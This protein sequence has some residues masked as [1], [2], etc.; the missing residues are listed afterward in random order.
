MEFW[1]TILVYSG[2]VLLAFT[3]L[4]HVHGSSITRC[5]AVR[6]RSVTRNFSYFAGFLCNAEKKIFFSGETA[7]DLIVSANEILNKIYAW[8]VANSLHINC[9][10]SKAVLFRAKA[11]SF[12]TSHKLILNNVEIKLC[13]TVKTLGVHFHEHMAWNYH[14]EHISHKLC[15]VLGVL[16]RCQNILPVKQ[17][18]LVYNALFSSHLHYCHLVWS[19]GSKASLKNLVVLQKNALR[20]TEG[21]SYNAHTASIFAKYRILR[22]TSYYE[23]QLLSAFKSEIRR[24]SILLRTLATLQPNPASRVNMYHVLAQT[25]DLKHYVTVFQV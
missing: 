16:R 14:A 22:I 15:K 4:V 6:K 17:K 18:I 23:Y 19:T 8:T 25:M 13:Q 2:S 11:R 5:I 10:K 21:V 20:C 24:G 1:L 7:D 12:E 3:G 9:F